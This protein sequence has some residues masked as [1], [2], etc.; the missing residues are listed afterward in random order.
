MWHISLAFHTSNH[1][2]KCPLSDGRLTAETVGSLQNRL[3]MDS[4]QTQSNEDGETV[5]LLTDTPPGKRWLTF[6]QALRG[7]GTAVCIA[8][9][10]ASCE[11]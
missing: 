3:V 4:L 7:V 8:L 11:F 6:S 10:V 2:V 1:N 5:P 9:I